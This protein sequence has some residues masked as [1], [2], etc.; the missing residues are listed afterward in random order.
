MNFSH[1]V[2][3]AIDISHLPK[4]LKKFNTYSFDTIGIMVYEDNEVY[5]FREP[6]K[7]SKIDVTNLLWKNEYIQFLECF[8][9][10]VSKLNLT[11]LLKII[12]RVFTVHEFETIAEQIFINRYL[13]NKD[14]RTVDLLE[15]IEYKENKLQEIYH[16]I[17]QGCNN[18]KD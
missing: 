16:K 8:P 12:K 9:I 15:D 4:F 17:T 11:N 7:R 14:F 1:V 2:Y 10:S 6:Y 18:V 3:I 5:V 13:D